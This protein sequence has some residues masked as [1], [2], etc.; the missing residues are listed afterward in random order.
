M[1]PV[2]GSFLY[3]TGKAVAALSPPTAQMSMADCWFSVAIAQNALDT[4]INRSVFQ[5]TT[6]RQ[7]GIN[8]LA[9]LERVSQ[10]TLDKDQDGKDPVLGWSDHHAITTQLA[11]FEA[12]FAAEMRPN[13]HMVTSTLG[14]DASKLIADG[15]VAFPKNLRNKVPAAIPDAKEAMKCI[16]FELPTAAGFHLHRANES[17]LHK[18][19]EAV[20][21]GK[22]AP[23][24]R[25]I[26][27]YLKKLDEF[28]AGD[29]IVRAALRDLKDL[30]RNPLI[31]PETSL[32]DVDEAYALYCGV[33][34]AMQA[35]LKVIPIPGVSLADFDASSSGPPD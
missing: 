34:A 29:K 3:A 31:H 8:L 2:D 35:M 4:L 28:S 7:E 32:D 6:S 27:D 30:H 14:L 19:Y 20:A 18:Y 1:L 15:S 17:V 21:P 11:Q 5:P 33:F 10:R 26:G 13:L 12:V 22:E 9:T 16:V 25:N 23:K 24:T